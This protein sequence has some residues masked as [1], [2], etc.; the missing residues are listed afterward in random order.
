[1]EGGGTDERVGGDEEATTGVTGRPDWEIRPTFS[2]SSLKLSCK[3]S[4]ISAS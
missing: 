1:L 2:L 4:T 3:P